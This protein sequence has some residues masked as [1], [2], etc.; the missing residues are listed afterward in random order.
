MVG[1]GEGWWEGVVG[2]VMVGLTRLAGDH[3]E[4]GKP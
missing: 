3:V 2:D 4:G 1:I